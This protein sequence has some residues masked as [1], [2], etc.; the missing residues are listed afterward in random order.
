MNYSI[1]ELEKYTGIK[2][3]TI[4]IWEQ[5]Y[6]VLTPHRTETNIRYYDDDQLRRLLN[7][8]SL[9]RSGLRISKISRMS[10]GEVCEAIDKLAASGDS[11]LMYLKD[12]GNLLTAALTFDEKLFQETF[13]NCLIKYGL[14]DTYVHILNPLL[15]RT[16][17]MWSTGEMNVC[18]EHFISNLVRQKLF[19]AA[20]KLSN[21][22]RDAETWVLFLPDAEEH[23]IGLL[24]ANFLIRQS[25]RKVIYL[26]Q[27]VPFDEITGNVDR[28][29]PDYMLTF[30]KHTK[31]VELAQEYI[32]RL[33]DVLGAY[34][35]IVAGN[36]EF[37]GRLD[38]PQHVS[39][40]TDPGALYTM[41]RTKS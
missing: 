18:Q 30:I 15:T 16:G 6:D 12:I 5:R 2:A 17:L 1:A 10:E 21:A 27:R 25:G 34:H 24:Y 31:Q 36:P 13:A 41:L 29:R 26:G 28:L 32:D 7:V 37:L 35:P 40:L 14:E 4:R 3:H 9:V 22:D 20:D 39:F 38:K 19:T 11:E 8:A 33:G 23:E